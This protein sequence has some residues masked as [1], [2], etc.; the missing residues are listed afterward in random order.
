MLANG[1]DEGKHDVLAGDSGWLHQL[2]ACLFVVKGV[3]VMAA[4]LVYGSDCENVKLLLQMVCRV[5]PIANSAEGHWPAALLQEKAWMPDQV[6]HDKP[7]IRDD[8]GGVRDDA[9]GASTGTTGPYSTQ[10]LDGTGDDRR[11]GAT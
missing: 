2:V 6:R 10:Q 9:C 11:M 5:A 3:A 7:D 8:A 1:E 4:T